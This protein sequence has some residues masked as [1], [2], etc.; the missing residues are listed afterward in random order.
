M[1]VLLIKT[2]SMGDLIHTLPA[3][4]DAG[5]AIPGIRFDW[6]VEDSFQE[7]P[8][9]HPLVDRV[10]PVALRRWRK[11]WL[12][13]ETRSGFSELRSTL[14]DH[15]YDLVLDAQGLVKSAFLAMF[16]NGPRA[17]LDF[18]SARETLAAL[19]YQKRHT[20]N[21]Y[22]HAVVR[23]RSLFSLAL[24]YDL[25]SSPPSFGLDRKQFNADVNQDYVVFLHG[26]TWPSKQW[27]ES[28]WQTL[29]QMAAA[30]GLRI[31]ISGGN[32]EEVARAERIAAGNPAVDLMPRLSISKM[33]EVLAG[34]R[35]AVAVDTGFGHLAGALDVPT[36]SIYG[37]T[38]PD[39][40]GA[41]G[42]QSVLLRTDFPCSPCLSRVCTYR[43]PSVVTPACYGTVPPEKVWEVVT[44]LTA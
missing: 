9:W 31:K 38:N 41:L 1:R 36:V 17:G 19:A 43:T 14:R 2:S 32:D 26:T 34:S 33:A 4:T 25:P 23:M 42:D 40:T 35:A 37:S 28:Y 8:A 20:V 16:A 6:M 18:R 44:K 7:I 30:Q 10:I 3:L 39:Y 15:S 5:R 11:G 13:K 24:Q 29:A 27:P 12:S 22:Q 21:F